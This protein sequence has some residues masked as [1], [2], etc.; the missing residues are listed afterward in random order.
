MD[1]GGDGPTCWYFN[2][3]SAAGCAEGIMLGIS[4]RKFERDRTLMACRNS[5]V[6]LSAAYF[7]SQQDLSIQFV[8]RTDVAV[9][10]SLQRKHLFAFAY[11]TMGQEATTIGRPMLNIAKTNAR[12]NAMGRY[13][14]IEV[15]FPVVREAIASG[16][17]PVPKENSSNWL[18]LSVRILNIEN[19][20][21]FFLKVRNSEQ[22]NNWSGARRY[23]IHRKI[24][25]L[26]IRNGIRG[27]IGN[28]TVKKYTTVAHVD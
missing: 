14:R 24:Y 4:K 7:V 18:H 20:L 19:K 13:L 6:F 21:L 12:V 3:V 27:M 9:V 16:A 28:S 10:P 26:I 17:I 8:N 2:D 5:V 11:F 22:S 1:R 23:T 15:I 25:T